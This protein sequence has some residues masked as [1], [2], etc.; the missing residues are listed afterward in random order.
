MVI[1]I[2]QAFSIAFLILAS[3]E[4]TF[5]RSNDSPARKSTSSTSQ[6]KGYLATLRITTPYSTKKFTGSVALSFFKPSVAPSA[7]FAALLTGPLLASAVG[8][9]HI[10]SLLFSAMPTFLFPSRL[11]YLFILPLALSLITY[12][13]TSTVSH[14]RSKP[15]RQISSSRELGFAVP[16]MV[17]GTVGLLAFGFYTMT[18]LMPET[19]G[20]ANSVFSLSVSPNLSLKTVS[21]LFGLMVSGAIALSYSGSKH[22]LSNDNWG[23]ELEAAKKMWE[24][25]MVGIFIMGMPMWVDSDQGMLMGLRST[26]I[27]LAVLSLVV[28]STVGAVIWVKGKEIAKVDGR[29]LGRVGER[30]RGIAMTSKGMESFFEA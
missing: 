23:S 18:A 4:T 10:I 21:G 5:N 13:L 6:L 3:P 20:I 12:T 7:L 19:D 26:N 15:P 11:G 28:G 30:D 24:E 16:G 29:L 22:L 17:I 25:V 14:L 9:S 8:I 1:N 2:I 27:A